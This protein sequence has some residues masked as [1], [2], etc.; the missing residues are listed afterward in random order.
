V[1][2]TAKAFAACDMSDPILTL[3]DGNSVFNIF[4]TK[5]SGLQT[6]VEDVSDKRRRGREREKKLGGACRLNLAGPV[7]SFGPA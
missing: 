5:T 6:G 7:W 3:D 4:I 2:V 1:Q